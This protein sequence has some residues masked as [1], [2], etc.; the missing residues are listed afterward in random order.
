MIGQLFSLFGSVQILDC[1]IL[2][3]ALVVG[4]VIYSSADAPSYQDDRVYRLPKRA[5]A[6]SAGADDSNWKM[7]FQGSWELVSRH[8]LN[9]V[10]KIYFYCAHQNFRNFIYN[11]PRPY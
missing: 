1:I 11:M 2:G 7:R 8:G 5:M 3:Y 10:L 4:L 9:E 6:S